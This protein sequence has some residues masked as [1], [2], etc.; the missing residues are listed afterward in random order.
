MTPLYPLKFKPIFKEKIWGGQKI[1]TILGKD[2]SPLRNCGELWALSGVEGDESVVENGFLAGNSLSE[3]IEIYMDELVG[4]TVYQKFGNTFPVLIKFLN[5]SDYLSVQV[6]PDDALALKRHRCMGKTEMWYIIDC[7]DD[8]ELIIGF[9]EGMDKEA[10]LNAMKNNNIK[11]ILNPVKIA[12]GDVIYLPAG[13]VHAIGKGLLLAEI[14]QTS[15]ITYRIYDWDRT[16]DKGNPRELHTELALDAID[17]KFEK[18]YFTPYARLKDI[19]AEIIKS[20]HFN[21]SNLILE[22]EMTFDLASRDS[23][24]AYV[25]VNGDANIVCNGKITSVS[26]GETVLMPAEI[27]EFKIQPLNK[28]TF[29]EV[30]I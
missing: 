12:A 17:F 24:T 5:S 8:S 2:F 10:Y 23:F 7:D 1:K 28:V 27:N 29:L 20:K 14:Q 22:K 26:G 3:L 13:R 30:Y 6:H 9:K 18:D 21:V 4:D 16:D 15:D 25:C 19:P 11:D